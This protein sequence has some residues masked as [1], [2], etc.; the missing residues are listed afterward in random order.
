M[1]ILKQKKSV[2]EKENSVFGKGFAELNIIRAKDLAAMDSNGTITR[3][4][5]L[6]YNLECL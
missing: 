5:L 1:L 4:A 6:H 2:K 3:D